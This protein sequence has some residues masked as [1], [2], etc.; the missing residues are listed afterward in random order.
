MCYHADGARDLPLVR[1][2]PPSGS[3]FQVSSLYEVNSSLE[4][5]T[6]MFLAER[7]AVREPR[8]SVSHIAEARPTF[9][10]R[11]GGI[12]TGFATRYMISVTVRQLVYKEVMKARSHGP[13]PSVVSVRDRFRRLV[14]AY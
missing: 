8:S 5:R 1:R 6:T 10:S 12:C 11:G 14:T 2:V 4:F 9:N 7:A 13:S 3:G